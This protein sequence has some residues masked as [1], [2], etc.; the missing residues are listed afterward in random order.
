MPS[1]E[2]CQRMFDASDVACVQKLNILGSDLVK[3]Y[4]NF[5]GPLDQS[6][7]EPMSYW[8]FA[9]EE[10]LGEVKRKVTEL[11]AEGKLE[12]WVREHDHVHTAGL[13]TIF[14]CKQIKL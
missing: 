6:W 12:Q 9:T 11:K 1:V 14:V 10:E 4:Y 7:R 2:Q 13:L 8:S 3:D 5:E